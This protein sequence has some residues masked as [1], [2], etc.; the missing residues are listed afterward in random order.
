[1]TLGDVGDTQ[2]PSAKMPEGV[3]QGRGLKATSALPQA[4]CRVSVYQRIPHR[5]TSPSPGGAPSSIHAADRRAE[6][7]AKDSLPREPRTPEL[8]TSGPLLLF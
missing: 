4:T 6:A 5:F 2:M 7:P 8:A 1:M 3:S